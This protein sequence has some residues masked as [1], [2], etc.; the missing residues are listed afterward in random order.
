MSTRPRSTRLK[1]ACR[2]AL[3]QPRLPFEAGDPEWVA[4]LLDTMRTGDLDTVIDQ[5]DE[6]LRADAGGGKG[7]QDARDRR[8]RVGSSRTS[9]ASS[10]RRR[11]VSTSV[12]EAVSVSDLVAAVRRQQAPRPAPPLRGWELPIRGASRRGAQPG[13]GA[14]YRS[15]PRR[16]T[17]RHRTPQGRSWI[18][19]RRRTPSP[20]RSARW[21]PG[22]RAGER[23]DEDRSRCCA[24][25]RTRRKTRS[26]PNDLVVDGRMESLEESGPRLPGHTPKRPRV[27]TALPEGAVLPRGLQPLAESREPRRSAPPFSAP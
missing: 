23:G 5:L 26:S 16:R 12:T 13:A 7:T 6:L 20:P 18:W 17:G 24:G 1:G 9:G 2:R 11:V 22:C 27:E 15:C 4:D 21:T 8:S 3:R 14:T 10:S 19:L 25:V